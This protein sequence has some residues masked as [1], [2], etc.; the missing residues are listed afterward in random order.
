[1]KRKWSAA[2]RANYNR[3]METK[4]STRLK[5]IVKSPWHVDAALPQEEHL[6]PQLLLYKGK[7]Y[8]RDDSI[9]EVK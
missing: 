4:R 6:A 2:Q 3:T 7:V 9:P 1:M 5:S 8:R